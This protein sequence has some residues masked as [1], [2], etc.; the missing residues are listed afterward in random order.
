MKKLYLKGG[1]KY[2]AKP[3]S[4]IVNNIDGG[5]LENAKRI[6]IENKKTMSGFIRETLQNL[7]KNK[8]IETK[9]A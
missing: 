5:I 4:I 6:L 8:G 1:E 2:M 9:Q 3:G 7:V